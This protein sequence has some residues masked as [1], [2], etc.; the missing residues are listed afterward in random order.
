M[1]A[2][3]RMERATLAALTGQ[4]EEH[5]CSDRDAATLGGRVHREAVAPFMRLRADAAEAGFD[6]RILS[7]FRSFERQLSIWNGKARGERPVL[8]GE[9]RPL[10]IG[11]LSDWEISLAILR[12]SA[13]PGAS[14]H[15]WGT[16]VDVY[17]AAAKPEGY[18]IELV[19]AEVEA[20]GMFGALHAWLDERIAADRAFRFFRPYDEDRGGVA[21]ER[22]HLSWAPV[23]TEWTR[24]L[25]PWALREAIADANME[26]RD[27]V[28]DHLDEIVERFVIN[29]NPAFR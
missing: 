27:A 7:G 24:L 14:R 29:I 8:D 19:P 4:A 25:T 11:G 12:W 17:D 16:D 6:L 18:E 5:L 13:L 28:L 3:G 10:D 2:S 21:P 15:H 23:A 22:W 9:S 20:G 1:N 26:G